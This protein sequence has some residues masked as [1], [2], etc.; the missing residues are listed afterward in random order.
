MN[1]YVNTPQ[2]QGFTPRRPGPSNQAIA[3]AH[4]TADPRY[5]M[6]GL[7]RAGVS[8]GAGQQY[9][10]GIQSAKNLAEGIAD[11]YS[12]DIEDQ[13]TAASNDL[14]NR[15][16]AESMGLATGAIQQQARYANALAALQRQQRMPGG[17]VLGGLTDF[18][19][20]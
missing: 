5:T 4:Q 2:I 8:R 17:N 6:K 9:L 3:A 14:A 19:G 7:D 15:E 11:A 10:A 1:T 13:A 20:Y 18:L 16:A 12:Q